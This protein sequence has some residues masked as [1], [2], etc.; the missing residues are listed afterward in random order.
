MSMDCGSQCIAFMPG[1]VQD[2][3]VESMM[4]LSD[5]GKSVLIPILFCNTHIPL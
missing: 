1:G 2:D 5:K 4:K 3:V